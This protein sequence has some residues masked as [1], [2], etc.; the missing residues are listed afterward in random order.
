MAKHEDVSVKLVGEDGNV[1]A[2][3]RRVGLALKSFAS[4]LKALEEM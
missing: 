2:I 4:I 3:I 1:F